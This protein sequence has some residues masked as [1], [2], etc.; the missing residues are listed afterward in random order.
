MDDLFGPL[1]GEAAPPP[2][3]T[4]PIPEDEEIPHLIEDHISIAPAL[5]RD[6][7]LY[8]NAALPPRDS[9]VAGA[10]RSSRTRRA[11]AVGAVLMAGLLGAQWINAHRGE[12]GHSAWLGP[13]LGTVYAALG[14]PLHLPPTLGKWQ[15]S[16]VNVTSDPELPG[17]L[18]I[19]G[20]LANRAGF[21]Q[22]WPVLRVVL[23]DRD[24]NPLRARDFTAHEYL[25]AGQTN[26]WLGPGMAMRF[27]LNVVD[28]GPDAV[29][30]EVRPCS[31]LTGD[32]HCNRTTG[33]GR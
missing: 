16:G 5:M 8:K 18:S 31:K 29:G 12:L 17:A 14:H 28:P 3:V 21:A 23:T 26:P 30:F 33:V 13:P 15:V 1:W 24:G 10:P 2:R 6:K 9:S 11:W 4:P 25:S 20:A 19:T 7:L 32:I 22:P 27:R